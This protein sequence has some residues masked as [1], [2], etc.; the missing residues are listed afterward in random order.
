M[1]TRFRNLMRSR[2]LT[3]LNTARNVTENNK[4]GDEVQKWG[5][6]GSRRLLTG[7]LLAKG[8]GS[9]TRDRRRQRRPEMA[10][11]AIGDGDGGGRS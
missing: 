6:A 7:R 9:G 5:W 3:K 1:A 4:D 2:N 8:F 10:T 11:D